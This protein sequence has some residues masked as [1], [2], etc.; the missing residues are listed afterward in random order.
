M[1]SIMTNTA[2]M[3]ALQTLR[4]VNSNMETTQSRISTGYRVATALGQRGLLVNR[5]HDAFRQQGA[6]GGRATRSASA[7]PRS[8]SP[9]PA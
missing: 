6:L 2:A 8:T 9:I 4:N 1:S 7:P 3:T 5:D